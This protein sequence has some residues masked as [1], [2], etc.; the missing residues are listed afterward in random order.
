MN[1]KGDLVGRE[2]AGC[3]FSASDSSSEVN[4]KGDLVGQVGGWIGTQGFESS[5][6]EERLMILGFGSMDAFWLE[7]VLVK[8]NMSTG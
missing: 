2:G 4:A 1:A 7:D 3:V 5:E 6:S 8:G